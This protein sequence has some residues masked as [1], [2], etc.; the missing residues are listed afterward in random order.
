MY[1]LAV[2][3]CIHMDVCLNI[4]IYTGDIIAGGTDTT[5]TSLSW[6]FAILSHYPKV[7][8]RAIKE[9][10]AFIKAHGRVPQFQERLDVPYC[11]AIIKESMRYRPTS[12]FGIPHSV[13]KDGKCAY[14]CADFFVF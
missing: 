1:N 7:Q 11:I 3:P 5:A 10:D 14:T 4:N 9:I 13:E 2:H 6:N 12:P 8:E